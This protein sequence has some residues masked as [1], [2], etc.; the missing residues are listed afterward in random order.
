LQRNATVSVV[1]WPCWS[2]RTFL[3]GPRVLRHSLSGPRLRGEFARG[4]PPS[5]LWQLL[6]CI[7]AWEGNWTW[8]CFVAFAW[9]GREGERLLVA[10]NYAPNQSQCYVRLPFADLGG[11]EWRMQ[12]KMGEVAYDRDGNDSQSRGLYL[13]MSPWQAYVF[14]LT[15]KS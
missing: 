11:S 6:E 2:F 14:A 12:D 4:V 8:D 7:S 13:D 10:V 3:S 1:I 9:Q 5:A 15:R